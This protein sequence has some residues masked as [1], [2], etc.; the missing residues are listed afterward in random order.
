MVLLLFAH[1]SCILRRLLLAGGV[2]E[3]KEFFHV[4][5]SLF[6]FISIRLFCLLLFFFILLLLN[7][8]KAKM[9]EKVKCVCAC[10]LNIFQGPIQRSDLID[11]L[12]SFR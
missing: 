12:L 8:F 7:L 3:S 11:S 9:K 1:A 10:F 4:L 5:F 6:A 2:N